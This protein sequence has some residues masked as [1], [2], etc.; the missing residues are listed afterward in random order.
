MTALQSVSLGL[1]RGAEWR[2]SS[3]IYDVDGRLTGIF[4][5]GRHDASLR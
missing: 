2:A 5:H 1:T 3:Y 4:G